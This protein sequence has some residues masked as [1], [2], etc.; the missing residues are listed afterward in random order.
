MTEQSTITVNGRGVLHV[1]P[2]I[3]RLEI[4]I[5]QTYATYEKAFAASKQNTSLLG[6]IVEGSHLSPSYVK[7]L[8]FDITESAARP[9]AYDMI[10][11]FR[12]D[13]PIETGLSST[14]LRNI[15]RQ[16]PGVNTSIGYTLKDSH[17]TQLE[18]LSR[19][20]EDAKEKAVVMAQA[21]SCKLGNVV[22]INYDMQDNT[23]FAKGPQISTSAT[24]NSADNFDITPQEIIISDEVA[25][26]W[27]L[28]N[29]KY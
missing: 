25:V 23:P 20:V 28:H 2:D 26:T 4:G 18:I 27:E 24:D 7:T 1:T 12:I 17:R 13:V 16:M 5:S 14:L 22:S 6:G 15:V 21:A 19:A 8:R 9:G 3:T 11:T 29:Y 10:Q